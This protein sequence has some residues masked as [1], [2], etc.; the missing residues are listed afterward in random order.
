MEEKSFSASNNL[1]L[2]LGLGMLHKYDTVDE[3]ISFWFSLKKIRA[4][5]APHI[6]YTE[7]EWHE[8]LFE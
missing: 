3:V 1:K 6:E 5:G 2:Q 4:I 8:G 7:H